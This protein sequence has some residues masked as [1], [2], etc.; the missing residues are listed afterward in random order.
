[1]SQ[2]TVE[3]IARV[4]HEANRAYCLA[5]GDA[6][7]PPWAEAPEWAKSSAVQGVIAVKYGQVRKPE[8]SHENWR[9]VKEGEGWKYG[10]VKDAEKREH[11]CL[12]PFHE[13]PWEQQVKDYLFVNI[14]R[15]LCL[16][17]YRVYETPEIVPPAVN[18][19][20]VTEMSG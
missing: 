5:L 12:V 13:L 8:D 2:L 18:P 11:P 3:A 9:R 4:C 6:S 16:E 19:S 10:P 20:T 17:P 15:T 7:Q 1:M 14:A